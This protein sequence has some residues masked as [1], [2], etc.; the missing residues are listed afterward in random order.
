MVN[1]NFKGKMCTI[2]W[3]FYNLNMS[4]VYSKILSSVLA[5][6]DAEYGNIAKMNITQGNIHKYLGMTINFS[7]PVKVKFSMV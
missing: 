4:H 6:I 3:Y 5:D 1:K 7:S 2:L